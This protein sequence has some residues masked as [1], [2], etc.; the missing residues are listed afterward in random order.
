MKE[1]ATKKVIMSIVLALMILVVSQSVCLLLVSTLVLIKIPEAL[2][3]VVGGAL[4]ITVSYFLLKLLINKYLGSTLEE[5]AIPKLKISLKWL[6]IAF[7]LPITITGVYLCMQG[8]VQ[9]LGMTRGEVINTITFGIFFSGLGAGFVEE[10]VFR[11]VIL[12]VLN[13]KCGTIVAII[14]PS[15]LFGF[16]HIIGMGFNILS[17]MLVL[18]SGTLV[19]IMFSLI[20]MEKHS[21]WNSA[22]VHAIWNMVII[23]GML[24]IGESTDK[25]SIY[26]YVLDS[27]LFVITGGEFGIEASIIAVI[28]YSIVASIAYM[29]LNKKTN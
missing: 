11:G 6:I 10:M 13:K 12:N 9:N 26:S 23:G 19:G 22:I 3:N 1:I 17:I 24:S 29:G 8:E 28:G 14:V 7:V 2:C 27:K 16:V 20:A 18:I 25:N 21:V 4:Y 5:F 15:L